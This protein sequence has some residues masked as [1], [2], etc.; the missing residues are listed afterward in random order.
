M[1]DKQFLPEWK[2]RLV[3]GVYR[4][5]YRIYDGDSWRQVFRD[6]KPAVFATEGE[7]RHAA[8]NV[9]LRII[10][11]DIRVHRADVT[12]EAEAAGAE[13]IKAWREAKARS[14]EMEKK[15]VF[16]AM[17]TRSVRAKKGR[18]VM[19]ERRRLGR[20]VAVD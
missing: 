14:V 17:P 10:N 5:W 18:V 2:P 1:N 13:E 9:V 15:K 4:A 8:R 7:A 16:G 3:N 19:V 20:R 11:R 6:G 12:A